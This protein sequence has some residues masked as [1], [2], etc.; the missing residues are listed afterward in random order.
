MFFKAKKK[1]GVTLIEVLA[2]LAILALLIIP[3]ANLVINS[4]STAKRSQDKQ[5]AY[6]A[7]QSVLEQIGN[8][9]NSK[10]IDSYDLKYTNMSGDLV[11]GDKI[12][13]P[14]GSDAVTSELSN[15]GNARYKMFV[16]L[17]K[18]L[19]NESPEERRISVDTGEDFMTKYPQSAL[20][21]QLSK[22]SESAPIDVYNPNDPTRSYSFVNNES[23]GYVIY[24][25]SDGTCDLYEDRNYGT[26]SPEIGTKLMSGIGTI[27]NSY[28]KL[29]IY[30]AGNKKLNTSN[31]TVPSIPLSGN[32]NLSVVS[33]YAGIN[34]L[35]VE[36][37]KGED[38]ST[39]LSMPVK[40]G[41][42]VP[43]S[44]HVNEYSAEGDLSKK[45][46]DLYKVTVE[47]RPINGKDAG[48]DI[49]SGSTTCNVL[50][51]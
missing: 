41:D 17:K 10:K 39:I 31:G 22:T 48:D 29:R 11:T 16:T 5:K 35:E 24:I 40:L 7:G 42:S 50:V 25:A 47:V 18:E 1:K 34:D 27:N 37:T 3:I 26:G 20:A 6:L 13:F 4:S 14:K 38:V 45:I 51:K 2:S 9:D 23:K 36:V 43:G 32:L 30:L 44:I 28:N 46:G 33:D 15:A 49:F 12:S 19:T 21:L 8:I